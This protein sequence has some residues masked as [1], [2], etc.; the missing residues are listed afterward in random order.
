[1]KKLNTL[2]AGVLIAVMLATPVLAVEPEKYPI[3]V[4]PGQPGP[5]APQVHLI[6]RYVDIGIDESQES[7]NPI[8]FRNG[9]YAFTGEHIWYFVLVR[10]ESGAAD[11][12]GAEWHVEGALGAGT[13]E[14]EALCNDI[15]PFINF[16]VPE[17]IRH[18]VIAQL[19]NLGYDTLTDKV[20][21][22]ILT[23]EPD[24]GFEGTIRV[25][26]C[27]TTP[28]CGSTPFETW[29]FNPPLEV[30]VTTSDTNP[31]RF[32]P[33]KEGVAFIV[34]ENCKRSHFDLDFCM[35]Q[36]QLPK[37]MCYAFAEWSGYDEEECD[38]SFSE[39]K[40]IIRNP[41][42]IDHGDEN[43]K[44]N[45]VVLWAFVAGSH[46]YASDSLAKCPYTNQLQIEQFEYR[47]VSGTHD[48]GWRIMPEFLENGICSGPGLWDE[49][50]GGC[51]IPTG[52]PPLDT[53]PPSNHVEFDLKIVWPKPCIGEFDTGEIYAIIR[54][55]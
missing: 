17:E 26:A 2:L 31:I 43:Y 27:D 33:I 30:E 35:N 55:V 15:T 13:W 21:E 32:G 8:D 34:K 39:N 28:E 54:A 50:R 42:M 9:Q 11:I 41:A 4:D 1:M 25:E 10:D 49:C 48:S 40:I 16:I 14:R 20:Y 38:V 45:P 36:L 44:P 29:Y 5:F 52:L 3:P 22:C 18:Y 46:F 37:C 51:R 47:A 53:I 23:V 6:L 24:F 7:I 12:T 19:T